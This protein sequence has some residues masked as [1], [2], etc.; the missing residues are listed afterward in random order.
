MGIEFEFMNMAAAIAKRL[1]I[2]LSSRESR[3]KEMRYGPLRGREV[4]GATK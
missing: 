4:A 2:N 1:E 3:L